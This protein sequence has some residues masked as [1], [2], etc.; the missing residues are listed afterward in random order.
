MMRLT[1][2]IYVGRCSTACLLLALL[3][4]ATSPPPVFAAMPSSDADQLKLES[5][6]KSARL[7]F[8]GTVESV[9]Y[10]MSDGEATSHTR[11]PQTYVTYAVE[12]ITHGSIDGDSQK[13]TLR[14]LG[15]ATGI[16]GR[17]M[18]MSDYPM[19]QAGDRDFV[20]VEHSEAKYCPLVGCSAG[21][22][23]IDKEYVFDDRGRQISVTEDGLLSSG[24][25]RLK[26]EQIA[27]VVPPAP[28]NFI[29]A[30]RKRLA[31]Q[32][33]GLSTRTLKRHERRLKAISSARILSIRSSEPIVQEV[34]DGGPSI[35]L[36]VFEKLVRTATGNS[37][38]PPPTK[39]V[40]FDAP[41]LIARPTPIE[42]SIQRPPPPSVKPPTRE[43]ELFKRN[44]G[45]PVIVPR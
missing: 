28:T 45:N 2:T 5:M 1:A 29:A 22:F 36:T 8:L 15:G 4:L 35:K 25:R 42:F 27:M 17:I 43:Q 30:E 16:D 38:T 44:G 3:L 39:S 23:R 20:F 41:V 9:R 6:G 10:R 34:G 13:I 24:V 19:F 11:L 12:R 21:R 40:D 32:K 37:R 18:R 33:D 31:A 14:F 7:I 26:A